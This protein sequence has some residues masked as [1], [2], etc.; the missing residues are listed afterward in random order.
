MITEERTSLAID[1]PADPQGI[2]YTPDAPAPKEEVKLTPR[3]AIEKAAADLEKDGTKIGEPDEEAPKEEKPKVEDKKR[4]ENGKFAPKEQPVEKQVEEPSEDQVKAEPTEEEAEQDGKQIDPSEGRDYDKPPA[5][6]LPRAKEKW[7]EVDP[8]VR[9]EVYRAI[10]T[11][12]KGLDESAEDR[13]F[14]KELRSFED[15]AKQ[16]GTS[17]PTY[18]ENTIRINQKLNTDLVGG[19]EDI[20]RQYGVSL[21]DVAQ[22]VLQQPQR[23]QAA[24]EVTQMQQQIQQLTQTIQQLTEGSAQQRESARL[25]E[26]E[27]TVIQP[28]MTDHPR[29]QELEPDIAFFLNSGKVPSNLPERQRLE[30]AYDMAERINPAPS[31]GQE[32]RTSATQQSRPLNPAGAKSVKGSPAPGVKAG[33]NGSYSAKESIA[34]AMDQIGF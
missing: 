7:G 10:E 12:Q 6:F 2:S 14:R 19:L 5:R 16:A 21:K 31:S 1:A 32:R 28:F 24:P 27:R 17:I 29:Y 4:A 15:M 33:A 9:S 23:P 18:L 3:E 11:M 25:S 34:A 8:D 22:H 26:V 20:V 30:V 13:Q